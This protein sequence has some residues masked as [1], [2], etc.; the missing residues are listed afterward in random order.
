MKHLLIVGARGFG[1]EVYNIACACSEFQKEFIIKGFLDD[2]STA[3]DEFLGYPPIIDSVENYKIQE[4]DVF[5]CAL[6]DVGY[7][8]SYIQKIIS[9]GGRFIS[10]IHPT[11]I[12]EKNVQLGEGCI[13]RPNTLIGCDSRIGNYVT[14]L[15]NVTIGHD[16]TI[17]DFS[18][19][20]AHSFLGGG[21]KVEE[22]VTIQTAACILP[23]KVIEKEAYVG[24][25]SV[26]MRN[27]KAGTKVLGNPAKKIDI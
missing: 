16:S 7:K 25:C 20:G 8:Y 13:I 4:D 15:G 24:V 18:H 23:H 1:R 6:G 5:T 27:V 14:V 22:Q 17:G 3:L 11:V 19:I 12:I 10:L 2:K 9:K 21:V 26:V